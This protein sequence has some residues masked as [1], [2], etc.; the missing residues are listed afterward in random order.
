MAKKRIA[1]VTNDGSGKGTPR[2]GLS[3]VVGSILSAPH[4]VYSPRTL[5]ELDETAARIHA[6]RPDVIAVAG[7]DGT[8]HQALN[9]TLRCYGDD[10]E[11][12]R[13]LLLPTGTMNVVATCIGAFRHS[14][15][16]LALRVQYKAEHGLPLDTARLQTLRVNGDH[17]FIY[18]AGLP[19]NILERYYEP[20]RERGNM[21]VAKLV[22]GSVLAELRHALRFTRKGSGLMAPVHAK[23]SYPDADGAVAP[24]LRHTGLMAATVDQLSFG[25]RV[26]PDAMA[27]PGRFMLRSTQLSFWGM[28]RNLPALWA[29]LP[30]P[31]THDAVPRRVRIEYAEP[32]TVTLDGDFSHAHVC[33]D[34][35]CGRPI[36]FI[37]G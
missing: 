19:V 35:V 29:G 4:R 1:L 33:D 36:T 24:H 27:L 9:R 10:D 28:F 25:C 30:L 22:F 7:G 20:G 6:E 21:G 14:A 18:G 15:T 31:R 34:V 32:T 2:A 3:R 5:E 26:F 11:F 13:V 37:T 16:D 23:I 17:C 8:L 12:P